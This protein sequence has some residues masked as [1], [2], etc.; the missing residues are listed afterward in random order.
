[1]TVSCDGNTLRVAGIDAK[2]V[3]IYNANGSLV[4]NAKSNVV[5]V[6]GLNG[7]YVVTATDAAGVAHT[8]KVVIR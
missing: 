4:A 5:N 1:M 3:S 8:T 7:V 6:K 2:N